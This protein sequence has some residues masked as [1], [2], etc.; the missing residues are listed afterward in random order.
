MKVNVDIQRGK[1]YFI[2]L[3]TD[4]AKEYENFNKLSE[5]EMASHIDC[6]K[7]WLSEEGQSN[8]IKM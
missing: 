7:A 1:A 6:L 5:S 4:I 8:S 2:R 3:Q